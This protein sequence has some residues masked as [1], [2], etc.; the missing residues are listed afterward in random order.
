MKN[1]GQ[2]ADIL[3]H[4]VELKKNLMN[5]E[6]ELASKDLNLCEGPRSQTGMPAT[7][8]PD[9]TLLNRQI[10]L[11]KEEI[12]A[13]ELKLSATANQMVAKQKDKK[14]PKYR[15][16]KDEY[17]RVRKKKN[18]KPGQHVDELLDIVSDKLGM[19]F[20]ATKKA[21]YYRPKQ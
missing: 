19:K 3:I 17:E 1:K 21:F 12:V 10:D 15:I 16:V 4:I 5:L 11:V 2:H 8:S 7:G 6:A 14:T 9:R 20:D 13:Y 18:Y